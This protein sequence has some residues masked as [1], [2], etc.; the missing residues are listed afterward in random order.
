MIVK[1]AF[2]NRPRQTE[3][4]MYM[5]A[6]YF[7][8]CARAVSFVQSKRYREVFLSI[9]NNLPA[10]PRTYHHWLNAI[11]SCYLRT[12]LVSRTHPA[13]SHPCVDDFLLLYGK[14][15]RLP[16]APVL[17]VAIINTL[18]RRFGSSTTSVSQ[19]K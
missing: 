5:S 12:V 13:T 4:V 14:L 17:S 2:V 9:E 1:L 15:R 11:Q 16:G 19:W 6:L 8:V 18:S 7:P 10:S 3:Q